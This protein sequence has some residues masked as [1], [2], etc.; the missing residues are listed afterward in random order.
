VNAVDY[1]AVDLGGTDEWESSIGEKDQLVVESLEM[2]G[3]GTGIQMA[4]GAEQV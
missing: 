4:S 3:T 2:C 1:E